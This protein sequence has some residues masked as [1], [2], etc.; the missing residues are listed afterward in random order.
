MG[1][2]NPI[3]DIID[4]IDDIVDGIGD[5]IEDV[6]GWLVPMPDI[7]DFG[8]LRPDQNAK[9]ILVN[10][11]SSNA[12]IPIIYGTRKVGGNVVFLRT[13]GTDNKYLYMAV[14]LGEGEISSVEALYINDKNL[15]FQLKNY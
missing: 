3:D 6:I 2:W 10:K 14:V 11:F 12:H 7:P 4:I 1:G 13:S 8:T 9:G 15:K 5:I